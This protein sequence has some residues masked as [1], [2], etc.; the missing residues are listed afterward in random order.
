IFTFTRG[1]PRLDGSRAN[2][3]FTIPGETS[4][5]TVETQPAEASVRNLVT[6]TGGEIIFFGSDLAGDEVSLLLKNKLFAGLVEVGAEW[7]VTSTEDRIFAVIQPAAGL[8]KTLPGIYSAIAKVTTR[9][10]GPD[11]KIRTFI[12]TSNETPFVV[13]PRIDSISAPSVTGIVTVT[14]TAFQD[15]AIPIEAVEVFV[16]SNKLPLKGAGPLNPGE[17]EVLNATTLQFRYPISGIAANETVPFRLI[18]NGT[19]SAPYWVIAP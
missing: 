15:A 13:T 5:T 11:K 19:E 16:G 2:V 1:A 14:G 10:I 17:F 9:R 4:P 6:N 3:T 12:K 8:E 18:M 7:G